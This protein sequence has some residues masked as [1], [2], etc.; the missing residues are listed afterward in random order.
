[1]ADQAAAYAHLEQLAALPPAALA[2]APLYT[3]L[4]H[5]VLPQLL[6]PG[7]AAAAASSRP[8]LSC[9]RSCNS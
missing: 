4:V 5:T 2:T 3:L 8:S 6:D 7:A 1:M 9:R